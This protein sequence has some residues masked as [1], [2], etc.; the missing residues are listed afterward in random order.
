[1]LCCASKISPCMKPERPP[2]EQR[3]IPAPTGQH[4]T[5]LRQQHSQKRQIVAFA[6]V[7]P[8]LTKENPQRNDPGT[9]QYIRP[10]QSLRPSCL[11][12]PTL[13]PFLSD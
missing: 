6:S 4:F 5:H 9:G 8:A 7:S 3:S 2:P 13:S 1:M 10:H 11:P 12:M